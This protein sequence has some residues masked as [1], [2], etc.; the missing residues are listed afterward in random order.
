MEIE[1]FLYSKCRLRQSKEGQTV[2]IDVLNCLKLES[3]GHD[4]QH[5]KV[6]LS[7]V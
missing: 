1:G 7:L 5:W 3:P 4:R 2:R 6:R